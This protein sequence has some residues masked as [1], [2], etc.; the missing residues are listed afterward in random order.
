[1]NGLIEQAK[2]QLWKILNEL[3]RTE[4]DGQEPTLQIALYEMEILLK[5]ETRFTN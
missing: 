4:K 1:M 5:L 2:S 3:A